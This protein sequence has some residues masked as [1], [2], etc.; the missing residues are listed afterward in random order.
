MRIGFV[1]WPLLEDVF[2]FFTGGNDVMF[3]FIYSNTFKCSLSDFLL[4]CFIFDDIYMWLL[5]FYLV[6]D[7]LLLSPLT[8]YT[9]R[10][11]LIYRPRVVVVFL[12]L[13]FVVCPALV[14]G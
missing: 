6:Y 8:I 3:Q 13:L 9:K 12:L 14:P 10:F 4:Y 1:E 2:C 7:L 11:F 5:C